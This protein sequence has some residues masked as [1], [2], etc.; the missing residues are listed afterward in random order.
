MAA[1]IINRASE[2]QCS[3]A[4]AAAPSLISDEKALQPISSGV[5][6][7]K[8]SVSARRGFVMQ[9]SSADVIVL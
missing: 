3:A 4:A 1:S 6:G 9:P 7:H 2:A 8:Q 5:V